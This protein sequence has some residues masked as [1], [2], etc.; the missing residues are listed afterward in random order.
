[1]RRFSRLILRRLAGSLPVLLLVAVGVFLL[2]DRAGGDAVDAYLGAIGGGDAAL[3]AELRRAWG[4]DGSS[5]ARLG[6]TLTRLAQGD[7]GWSVALNRPV[8]TAVV[9]RLPQTLW[10]LGSATT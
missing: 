3:A 8:A 2:L 5:W 6:F 4:L 9:E 10:L 7:L 1:M